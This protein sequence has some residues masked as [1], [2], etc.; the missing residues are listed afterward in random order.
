[1][2]IISHVPDCEIILSSLKKKKKEHICKR[3]KKAKIKFR[4]KKGPHKILPKV[5][6]LHKAAV[7]TLQRKS[8][9]FLFLVQR[10]YMLF[11]MI[12]AFSTG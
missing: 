9:H 4:R 1:M 8:L 12:W 2:G 7:G 3:K 11:L 5:H 10:I 6:V